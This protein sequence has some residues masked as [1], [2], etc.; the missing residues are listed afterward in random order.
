MHSAIAGI[1]TIAGNVVAPLFPDAGNSFFAGAIGADGSVTGS[2]PTSSTTLAASAAAGATT[3]SATATLGAANSIIQIDSN[4]SGIAE[5]HKIVSVSGAGPYTVTLS[6]PLLRAHANA[7]ALAIVVAPYTHTINPAN[8]LPSFTIE[9]N[10]N[11]ADIQ[12]A[13]AVVSKLDAKFSTTAEIECT[14]AFDAQQASV[15]GSPSTPVFPTDVPFGPTTIVATLGGT[16]DL[17]VTSADFS[18]DNGTKVYKTLNGFTYPQFIVGTTR[19]T[20]MKISAILQA[21]S[22]GAVAEGYFADLVGAPT[23]AISLAVTQG[24]K[25]FTISLV[26]AVLTKY[27]NPIK[28]GD[29]VAVDLE[30]EALTNGTNNYDVTATIVNGQ[31]LS[32]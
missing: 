5:C 15:L 23:N 12:Y 4:A 27:S 18:L 22:G 29:L 6:E 25:T 13:G 31:Y 32:Y 10:M 16:A 19:K 24:T 7:A 8:T 14:Y 20:S 26:A 1:R 3:I 28:L 17:T 21:L 11:G 30:Y 9:K 2:T